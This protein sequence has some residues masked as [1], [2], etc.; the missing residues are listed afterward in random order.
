ML[1]SLIGQFE[2]STLVTV[3]TEY[4]ALDE[5]AHAFIYAYVS[6]GTAHTILRWMEDPADR[7]RQQLIEQLID[8]LP[9][10]LVS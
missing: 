5:V 9:E 7:D 10:R 6:A 3:A 1:E 2:A 8:L 4:S